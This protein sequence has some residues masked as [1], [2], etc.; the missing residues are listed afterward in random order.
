MRY[1]DQREQPEIGGG[2]RN[3][4]SRFRFQGRI[5]PVEDGPIPLLS[6]S[7]ILNFRLFPVPLSQNREKPK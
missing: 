2:E 5:G 7:A 4:V 6:Q 1:G 3:G